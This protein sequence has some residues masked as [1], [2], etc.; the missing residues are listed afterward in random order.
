[1]KGLCA[2]L[3][4]LQTT[5]TFEKRGREEGWLD[6]HDERDK[7]ARCRSTKNLAVPKQPKPQ[8]R[9]SPGIPRPTLKLLELEWKSN[10]TKRREGK[11]SSMKQKAPTN[12]MFLKIF[13]KT[14]CF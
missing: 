14:L 12:D 9:F 7:G 6:T 4:M 5:K 1:L 3:A 11:Q 2:L 13:V 8:P 10:D